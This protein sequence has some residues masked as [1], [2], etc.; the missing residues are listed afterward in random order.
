MWWLR[1]SKYHLGTKPSTGWVPRKMIDYRD[2]ESRLRV[3]E[4]SNKWANGGALTR[5]LS[6]FFSR[7][8]KLP[9][10]WV[11]IPTSSGT[12]ALQALVW[13]WSHEV[14]SW[15]VPAYSWP[16]LDTAFRGVQ[17]IE[18]VDVDPW[19]GSLPYDHP[20]AQGTVLTT[21]AGHLTVNPDLY[22]PEMRII[23]D[24]CCSADLTYPELKRADGIAI[25]LHHTKP[26][27]FGEGG[28]AAVPFRMADKVMEALGYSYSGPTV[29][30]GKMSEI[31][32]AIALQRLSLYSQIREY[33]WMLRRTLLNSI[34]GELEHWPLPHYGYREPFSGWLP[35]RLNSSL[36]GVEI[37]GK[38]LGGVMTRQLYPPRGDFPEAQSW[39]SRTISIP[40][41]EGLGVQD[42]VRVA[43][44]LE[45]VL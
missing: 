21:L 11:A 31:G 22:S 39:Y 17:D 1:K 29:V 4:K 10:D 34:P 27:G 9:R 45:I 36:K 25:S 35:I 7:H 40:L 13:A 42:M 43:G 5:K 37:S 19:S 24:N 41:H 20:G 8:L 2:L 23:W 6:S 38:A 12:T 33:C 15:A 26:W 14:K 18:V 32:A 16:G 44:Q 3:A 30:N 28:V